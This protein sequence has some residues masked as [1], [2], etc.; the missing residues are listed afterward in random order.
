MELDE[1]SRLSADSRVSDSN[2]MQVRYSERSSNHATSSN[3]LVTQFSKEMFHD[4]DDGEKP[5]VD[6]SKPPK[7]EAFHSEYMIPDDFSQSQPMAL[8]NGKLNYIVTDH[9][10]LI[11]ESFLHLFLSTI[12]Q[13]RFKLG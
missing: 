3:G 1:N 8:T 11:L 2:S 10:Y 12:L 6:M 13:I 4:N 7:E 5:L 9:E